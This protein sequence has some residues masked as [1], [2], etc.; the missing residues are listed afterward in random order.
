MS[1]KFTYEGEVVLR[2]QEGGYAAP[3]IELADCEFVP[4]ERTANITTILTGVN[5][6]SLDGVLSSDFGV[7]AIVDRIGN[8]SLGKLRITVERI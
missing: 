1:D 3:E 2:C 7:G 5:G 8:E 4:N 6:R